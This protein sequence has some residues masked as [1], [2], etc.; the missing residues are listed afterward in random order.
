MG[1]YFRI[2]VA[3]RRDIVVIGASAGGVEALLRLCSMLKP[4]LNASV[5][6]VLHTSPQAPGLLPGILSRRSALPVLYPEDGQA[7]APNTIYIAPPNRHLVL[8]PEGIQVSSG[9]K[10]NLFRPS[11]DTLFRSAAQSFEERVVG[12]MLTGTLF[13]GTAGLQEI[14]R[15]GGLTVVQDPQEATFP[16]LPMNAIRSLEVD[17]ILN[18]AEIA[19]V[20]HRLASFEESFVDDRPVNRAVNE[21]TVQTGPEEGDETTMQDDPLHDNEQAQTDMDLFTR[22]QDASPRTL[23][24]C[25]ECG[26]VLRETL[27]GKMYRYTCHEG[28]SYSSEAML[29]GQNDALEKALW[30]AERALR[31]RAMLLQRMKARAERHGHERVAN[32]YAD[33]A[34]QANR[35]AN[36]L[37]AMLTNGKSVNVDAL[38][39]ASD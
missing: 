28:H 14:Q 4:D 26:G 15:R 9:P 38:V 5:F 20:L 34:E 8:R 31:E 25:P 21:T 1:D 32:Q 22:A 2:G 3:M 36:L 7:F 24:T 19:V 16:G 6:I 17:Y 37:K 29:I 30:V 18:L 33:K 39:H 13:D 10:V 23:L 11:I 27:D 12:V 35:D